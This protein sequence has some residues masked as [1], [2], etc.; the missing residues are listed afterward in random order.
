MLLLLCT[1]APL[2]LCCDRFDRGSRQ[3]KRD[4]VDLVTQ[5]YDI[6]LHWRIVTTSMTISIPNCT[7]N[8]MVVTSLTS[9]LM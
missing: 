5:D 2:V 7:E 1:S 8:K 3:A 4:P 6:T 9:I